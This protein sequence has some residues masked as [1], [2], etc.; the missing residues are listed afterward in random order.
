[1]MS[2][3]IIFLGSFCYLKFCMYEC[4]LT[5]NICK[6]Y[7]I[8]LACIMINKSKKIKFDCNYIYKNKDKYI[9]LFSL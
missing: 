9:F 1:M 8:Y 3:I 7:C 5:K 6:S 2:M 4:I